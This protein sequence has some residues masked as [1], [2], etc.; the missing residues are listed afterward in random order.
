M[1]S[2]ITWH[3][4]QKRWSQC[5]QAA[6]RTYNIVLGSILIWYEQ[7]L[8]YVIQGSTH[9]N[10]LFNKISEAVFDSQWG[11]E[12]VLGPSNL[13][14]LSVRLNLTFDRNLHRAKKSFLS[15]FFLLKNILFHFLIRRELQFPNRV[16]LAWVGS[17]FA[18]QISWSLISWNLKSFHRRLSHSL[19]IFSVNVDSDQLPFNVLFSQQQ[20]SPIL[21][22]IH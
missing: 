14:R 18:T 15:L 10:D 4:C 5:K 6:P 22:P 3:L 21:R 19:I 12:N 8:Q 9:S 17:R 20:L 1:G 2:F 7:F 11:A 13:L 16:F